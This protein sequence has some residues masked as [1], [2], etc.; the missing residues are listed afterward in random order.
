MI[1][2]G[3]FLNKEQEEYSKLTDEQVL[4]RLITYICKHYHKFEFDDLECKV[5]RKNDNI[6]YNRRYIKE[7]GLDNYELDDMLEFLEQYPYMNCI[8]FEVLHD[9]Q[10]TCNSDAL[11]AGW[12]GCFEP[13]YMLYVLERSKI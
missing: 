8:S 3:E 2:F 1:T 4:Q 7:Y 6:W 13:R 10:Q 9:M 5:K 12:C 11:D